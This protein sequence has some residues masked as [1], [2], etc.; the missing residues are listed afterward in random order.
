MPMATQE[1][2]DRI[3]LAKK[4]ANRLGIRTTKARVH[5]SGKIDVVLDVIAFI[6]INKDLLRLSI[7]GNSEQRDEG[8]TRDGRNTMASALPAPPLPKFT[9]SC[10]VN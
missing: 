1:R 7:T 4:A 2:A 10:P 3:F 5:L 9:T 8:N 6:K